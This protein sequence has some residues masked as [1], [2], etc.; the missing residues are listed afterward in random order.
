MRLRRVVL[1]LPRK[2]VRIVTGTICSCATVSPESAAH[3][4]SAQR[5][6]IV[7]STRSDRNPHGNGTP[8]VTLA[9]RQTDGRAF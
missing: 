4:H 5:P 6:L 7:T 9:D 1:P 8:R 3:A 2:P